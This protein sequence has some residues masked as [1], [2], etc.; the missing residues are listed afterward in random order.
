[1]LSRDWIIFLMGPVRSFSF[2]GFKL[3]PLDDLWLKIRI[4]YEEPTG[5]LDLFSSN[6]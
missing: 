3:G 1:M 6:R 4:H 2:V 5:D